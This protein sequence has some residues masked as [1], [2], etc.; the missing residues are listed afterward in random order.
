MNK[1][2]SY[3]NKGALGLGSLAAVISIKSQLDT[4]D[5]K[6]NWQQVIEHFL[7]GGIIGGTG[8]YA[9]GAYRDYV[10]AKEILLNT[11]TLIATLINRIRL[12]KS[13]QQY[14]LLDKK[15][16]YI[17]AKLN[18]RF[19]FELAKPLYK[20]GSTESETALK[21]E[22]DI[23][24]CMECHPR[25]FHST[26]SMYY[27]VQNHLQSLCNKNGILAVRTQ[28]VSIGVYVLINGQQKR[29]DITPQKRTTTRRNNTSGYLCLNKSGLFETPGR[30]K[31]DVSLL[32][33]CS[34]TETQKKILVTLKFLK[35]KKGL[36]ISSTLLQ[37]LITNCYKAYR[38]EIPTSFTKKI[39][40]VLQYIAD[41][42]ETIS[43]RS[44]EN[45][46]NVLT[47]YM[48]N[49]EKNAIRIQCETIVNDYHYQPNSILAH[50]QI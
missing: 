11:D 20:Y 8:G 21:A 37:L 36:P 26:E 34:L 47:D 5:K 1:K 28:R 18:H 9:F 14:K 33:Q 35:H 22:A 43:I 6:I 41:N 2:E 48:S 15:A 39:I 12:R 19:R 32:K 30:T 29:I 42:I 16:S 23:D 7:V 4:P 44:L 10:N 49:S 31:T 46:N 27:S 17:A 40:L 3:A 25:S 45:T 50:L 38:G 13:D 24:M